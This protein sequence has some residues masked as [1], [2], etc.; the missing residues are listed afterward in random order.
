MALARVICNPSDDNLLNM[1]K[2]DNVPI[3]P[4]FY[5]PIVPLVLIN[6]AEGIGTGKP[7]I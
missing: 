2:D 1:Q 6:G 3:E 4:E 7:S 5:M